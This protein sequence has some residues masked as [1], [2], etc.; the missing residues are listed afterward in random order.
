MRYSW[1]PWNELQR[2]QRDMNALVDRQRQEPT[3]PDE[4]AWRPPVDIFEDQERY[5]VTM[6]IPGMEPD[7]IHL[8]VEDNQLS[9]RGTR[10][11]EHEDRRESY[12]RIERS[13]GTFARTFSLPNT[14]A[15]ESIDA[16][17]KHGLLRISIPKRAEVQ[18]KRID[19]K[20]GE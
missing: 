10:G 17:Y 20:V 12:H 16:E 14:V 4:A 18:P 19:V 9:V 7:A 11:M 6:E 15:T 2:L 1:N 5:L 13:Y 3:V 8:D